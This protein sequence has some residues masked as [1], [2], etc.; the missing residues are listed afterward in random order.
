MPRATFVRVGATR[1]PAEAS[2]GCRIRLFTGKKDSNELS[3]RSCCA[4]GS[5]CD[6]GG[7]EA[8][9]NLLPGDESSL[10]RTWLSPCC[11]DAEEDFCGE[12]T[13]SYL[14]PGYIRT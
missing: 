3:H 8:L 1:P 5:T 12:Y 11:S 14:L 7:A 6:L 2:N 10:L 9:V 4:P 13:L